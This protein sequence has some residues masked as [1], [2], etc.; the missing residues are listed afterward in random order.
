MKKLILSAA[1]LA[2]VAS[3]STNEVTDVAPSMQSAIGFSTLNDRV[4]KAANEADD[5]YQVYAVSSSSDATAFYITDYVSCG[6][7]ETAFEGESGITYYWPTDGSTLAFYAYAPYNSSN[8]SDASTYD[9]C[10]SLTYV[11]EDDAQEDFTLA[12]VASQTSGVVEFT[13]AHLLS[14]VTVNVVLEETFDVNYDLSTTAYRFD[15]LLAENSLSIAGSTVTYAASAT[16][17]EVAYTSAANDGYYNV[18]PQTMIDGCNISLDNITISH[19]ESGVKLF[20]DVSLTPIS[21]YEVDGFSGFEP[22]K[23][24]EFTITVGDDATPD[25]DTDELEII[26][27]KATATDWTSGTAAVL[28]QE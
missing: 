25:D 23:S 17:A 28:T 15:L 10:L 21:L 20:D 22:G 11:V 12:S 6:D 24:Y 18:L 14:K 27:F 19:T 9:S 3:C 26:T 16:T 13:F 1:V 8:V 2:I 4:T 7:A 5:D